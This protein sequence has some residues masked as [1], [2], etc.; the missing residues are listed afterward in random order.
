MA[1]RDLADVRQY[2]PDDL[3]DLRRNIDP[4]WIEAALQ[5]TGTATMRR[6]RMPAEQVVW[7]VI[8]MALLRA[9]SIFEV[10]AKLDLSLPGRKPTAAPSAVSQSRSRLGEE[11][12]AWLFARCADGWAH[13]SARRDS[14]CELALYGVDGT[15]MLVPD[16]VE[17]E[18]V[19]GKW[20]AGPGE[21]AFPLVRLV[22]LM[23]LRSH[24]IAAVEFG[25][26]EV[27]ETTYAASL[28]R[29]LPDDSLVILDKLYISAANL[30][31]LSQSGHGRYW[32]LRARKNIRY[33]VVEQLGADDAIVEMDV[34]DE[35]R[36][37][38]PSL[39]RTWRARV[40]KYRRKGFQEQTLL[41]SLMDSARFP[42]DEIARLYHERWE[43]EL[44]YDELKTELLDANTVLR[45]KSPGLVRQEIW[46]VLL[47]YNLV[48]LEMER[49]A[50]EA[51]VPPS[52]ISFTAALHLIVDEWLWCAIAS[53]GAIPRHLRN[54][55]T[56]LTALVLPERRPERRYPR[57]VKVQRKSY[58]RNRRSPG[59]PAAK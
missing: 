20:V 29:H 30:T 3:T 7:L 40:I 54:L 6:R 9:R 13:S 39:P 15:K 18:E 38:D 56:A 45:S 8:G 4:E 17:N 51:K 22:A 37:K 32:L 53:P 21:S 24:L 5:A 27:A 47:A 28:W 2:T 43:I 1:L 26:Y 19:F 12:L 49:V 36:S 55:R 34:S 25:T 52:R 58:P 48:R 46:G 10:A 11:P 33:R 41:T 14:W 42:G 50:A 16:T 57:E 59:R 31:A 23:A 35:A 44:G